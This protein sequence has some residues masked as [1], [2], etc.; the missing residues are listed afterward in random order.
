MRFVCIA[1]LC[2]VDIT[3]EV[4]YH[5]PL[6]VTIMKKSI[7]II[8]AAMLMLSGCGD[9][10]TIDKLTSSND[11]VQMNEIDEQVAA[12]AEKA[13]EQQDDAMNYLLSSEAQV[14]P[15]VES[16]PDVKDLD[17]TNGD[18]DI[19]LTTLDANMVYAEV[20]A[21]MSDPGSFKSKKVRAK[22]TFAH[23]FDNGKD[24]YAVFIS[25]AAACCQQGIEFERTG[26]FAFP[27]DYPA[28]DA[29][30]MVEGFFDTYV[31][32]GYTYCTLRDAVM[33]EL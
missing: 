29:D 6:E 33:T 26:E 15:D 18:I 10:S 17:L 5:I 2:M 31:E 14:T 7:F 32:D 23:T 9:T 30:I 13:V 25:D 28:I 16:R 21:M 3:P 24:Y 8:A 27:D 11:E 4:W 22:G 19:D 1:C 20:Y 12:E